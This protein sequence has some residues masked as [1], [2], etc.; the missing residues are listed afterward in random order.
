MN[1]TISI[2]CPVY[3]VQEFLQKCVDSI[4]VQSFR[5]W[6]LILVDDG[7]PDE[8]GRICDE[9]AAKD[10]RIRV[11]HKT[12]GGVS[13]ARQTGLEAAKGEYI[14]HADPD[15]WTE[16]TMLEDLYTKAKAEN[17]DVVICDY[18][19]NRGKRQTYAKQEPTSLEPKRVLKELFQQ[20]LGSCWNKLV[21]QACYNRYDIKFPVGINY[22]E[23]LLVCVQLF[24]HNDIKIA[25][26]PKAFYHYRMNENSITHRLTRKNYEGLLKYLDMLDIILQ[27]EEYTAIKEKAALG[28]FIES[29]IGKVMTK[30]ET[31]A[32]FQRVKSVAYSSGRGLRWKIG[33]ML[34]DSGL[35]SI[36]HLFIKY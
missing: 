25:Y 18:F 22:C 36:A 1:P 31:A 29:F 9:Y 10:E 35:Y 8:S 17:A 6:E 11:I 12:N 33:Y 3:N 21:R 26:L 23:D 30:A 5:D 7:S 34:I 14:I 24:I 13:S 16:P 19:I 27:E 2:I 15:D 28:V 32:M 4:V 20:L